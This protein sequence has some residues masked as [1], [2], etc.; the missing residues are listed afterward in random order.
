MPGHC[1]PE[2]LRNELRLVVSGTPE[3]TDAITG[4]ID[5]RSTDMRTE[6][7]L[8]LLCV[9]LSEAEMA[10]ILEIRPLTQTASIAR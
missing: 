2:S 10:D 9:S 6:V 5:M 1:G 8:A 7:S 4:P 3:F